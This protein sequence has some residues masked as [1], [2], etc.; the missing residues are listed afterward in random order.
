MNNFPA[1]YDLIRRFCRIPAADGED[2]HRHLLH[3]AT[4]RDERGLAE[5]SALL[6]TAERFGTTAV[7]A[8]PAEMAL[9]G[10]RGK[11]VDSLARYPKRQMA[12]CCRPESA[13]LPSPRGL[14]TAFS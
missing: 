1:R 12:H 7:R 8:R 4:D 9:E 2:A 5:G 11:D 13:D 14:K 10:W 3:L 6:T